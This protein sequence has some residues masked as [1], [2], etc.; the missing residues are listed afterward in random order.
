MYR[1]AAEDGI[2]VMGIRHDRM[3]LLRHALFDRDDSAQ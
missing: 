1:V 3:D 2:E